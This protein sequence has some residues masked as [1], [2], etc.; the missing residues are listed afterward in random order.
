MRMPSPTDMAWKNLPLRAAIWACF[1][2]TLLVCQFAVAAAELSVVSADKLMQ[3]IAAE[4]PFPTRPA[5]RDDKNTRG[6]LR[7]LVIE[8]GR[9]FGEH[10]SELLDFAGVVQGPT[11]GGNLD[12]FGVESIRVEACMV[13]AH[14]VSPSAAIELSKVGVAAPTG[15]LFDAAY[16]LLRG[17]RVAEAIQLGE[18]IGQP[19]PRSAFLLQLSRYDRAR[20]DQRGALK[21][22][23]SAVALAEAIEPDFSKCETL[24]WAASELWR[25]GDDAGADRLFARLRA[26]AVQGDPLEH[27]SDLERIAEAQARVRRFSDALSTAEKISGPIARDATLS[28]IAVDAAKAGDLKLATSILEKLRTPNWQAAAR[29]RI[30][31]VRFARGERAEALALLDAASACLNGRPDPFACKVF[32]E[33]L[34]SR[35]RFGELNGIDRW[36]SKAFRLADK[37]PSP[38]DRQAEYRK[39][40][41]RWYRVPGHV[42]DGRDAFDQAIIADAGD[43]IRAQF[44]DKTIW[45][46]ALLTVVGTAA[47]DVGDIEYAA[48]LVGKMAD[49]DAACE[50][51][52]RLAEKLAETG[53]PSGAFKDWALVATQASDPL[54]SDKGAVGIVRGLTKSKN[55]TAARVMARQIKSPHWHAVATYLVAKAAVKHSDEDAVLNWVRR[56]PRGPSRMLGIL[57]FVEGAMAL[58]GICGSQF[59]DATAGLSDPESEEEQRRELE[60][61]RP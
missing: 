24:A 11:I 37:E 58:H 54:S 17:G 55:V 21:A 48:R 20:G 44:H 47:L 16:S 35:I 38:A 30:A 3:E 34:D 32:R 56:E 6:E 43:P 1:A 18:A 53:D 12:L 61:L 14:V 52:I 46:D 45:D 28:A 33:L 8:A 26:A 36:F 10:R 42:R 19:S 27:E 7:A 39:F 50:L 59:L 57:G 2:T 15:I 13:T 5:A 22:T 29:G 40:A 51:R 25:A 60:E 31:Q 23:R 49:A 41:K 9:L 4:T